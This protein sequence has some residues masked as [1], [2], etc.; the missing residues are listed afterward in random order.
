MG[1]LIKGKRRRLRGAPQAA[2]IEVL[3]LE[4]T[5]AIQNLA[6]QVPLIRSKS[7]VVRVYVKCT[8]L[9]AKRDL[10]GEIA[11]ASAPGA[12]ARYVPSTKSI[13][14]SDKDQPDLGMQRRNAEMSLN[15]V[16]PIEVCSWPT[17]S[18]SVNHIRSADTDLPLTGDLTTTLPLI[19]SPPLRIKVVGL[20]YVWTKP[21][22]AQVDISPEAFHFDF[23]RSF[24]RRAYPVPSIEWSQLVVQANPQFAPPFSGPQTPDGDDPLWRAKLAIAHNQLAALRAKDIESGTDPRT[25]YYGLVSDASAGLFFRG[26]AKDIP[27][28]PDPSVVAV[29]PTGNPRQYP[30]LN[31]DKDASYGDWYAAH[32]LSHTFG[33]FH[34]GFCGQDASDGTF[35]YPDGRIGDLQ[36]GDMIGL[37]VGDPT[38]NIPM[39]ALP[40]EKWHDIMTYCDDQWLSSHSYGAILDRLKLEDAGFRVA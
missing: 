11:V 23:L 16:L 19:D 36:N 10:R 26:A 1:I 18:I 40:H 7:T 37:D 21:G 17:V 9:T 31:W 20:R 14:I 25:H 2:S 39:A 28:V 13:T 35:P 12:P 24:L 4:V 8:G 3:G 6:H 29:G 34:P 30:S 32:E 27:Q 5:Q 22:G 33:R 15:F 38:L